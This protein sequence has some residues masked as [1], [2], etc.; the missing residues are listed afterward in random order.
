MAFARFAAAI[1]FWIAFTVP[2][3][4]Q[5][6]NPVINRANV[7]PGYA[8]PT[9]GTFSIRFPIPFID[10]AQ[11]GDSFGI[12]PDT[13]VR[14]VTG[15]TDGGIRLSASEIPDPK[16]QL[17]SAETFM[18]NLKRRL[19]AGAVLSD[20]S[21]DRKNNMEISSFALAAHELGFYFRVIR[22]G[23]TEY[24]LLVQFPEARRDAATGMKDAFFD[25]F[26]LARP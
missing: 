6:G 1:C 18:D 13:V 3:H 10:M 24:V 9:G 5:V 21:R 22:V 7:P 14:M 8:T 17:A 16:G 23:S 12:D 19:G 20:V 4:A 26:S 11:T 15:K 2:V 25:S